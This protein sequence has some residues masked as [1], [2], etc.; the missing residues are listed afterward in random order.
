ME[1]GNATGV[2]QSS[3]LGFYGEMV[4][5]RRNQTFGKL[6]KR[7][8]CPTSVLYIYNIMLYILGIWVS[9][10]VSNATYS[11]VRIGHIWVCFLK[12]GTPRPLFVHQKNMSNN[13]NSILGN[14][15]CHYH[16][17]GKKNSPCR[18]P[19]EFRLSFLMY[20]YVCL[21]ITNLPP[22]YWW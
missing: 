1:G 18:F 17:G 19:H 20:V 12:L 10:C 3:M 14:H 9:L 2:R 4:C 6:N 11:H 21:Y 8:F 13:L 15:H 7:Y 22:P 16:Y 5:R